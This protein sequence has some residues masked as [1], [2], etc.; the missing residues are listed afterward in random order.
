MTYAG[1]IA[2]ADGLIDWNQSAVSIARRVRA[3]NPWPVAQTTLDGE[4]LRCWMAMDSDAVPAR[5]ARAGEVLAVDSVGIHVQT[6]SGV[7]TLTEVQAA[8]RKRL[9]AAEFARARPL[10]GTGLGA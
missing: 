1:R 9:P 5:A 8:G 2:K 4:S 7:L 10:V 3:Y 6:G